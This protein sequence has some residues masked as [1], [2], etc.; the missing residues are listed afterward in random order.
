MK[1]KCLCIR[2]PFR[3]LTLSAY[4]GHSNGIFSIKSNKLLVKQILLVL[5]L[6]I[7]PVSITSG[8][9]ST[10]VFLRDSNTPIELVDPNIPHIYQDIMVGTKLKIVVSSDTIKR[11]WGGDLA[12]EEAYW[13]YGILTP[14]E[15]LPAAGDSSGIYEQ[16]SGPPPIKW[17]SFIADGDNVAAGDWFIID[18][19]AVD[20][21]DYN[22]VDFNIGFYDYD[23]SW[24]DPNYYL[25][26]SQVRTRDFNNNTVV[27]FQDYAILASYW[28]QTNCSSSN[29][30]EGA[31]LNVDGS[32][33]F[34]DLM[35]FCEFWLEKT[36]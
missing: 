1:K 23:I 30:C 4:I 33:D 29:G 7:S 17:I 25:C 12:L 32:V 6:I 14:K 31:D 28:Q 35:L 9:I 2:Y 36:K 3:E 18:Y 15:P 8:T 19:N 22:S 16:E 13:P 5:A 11:Y 21:G 20:T 26:F 24:D 34:D 27:D 10:N